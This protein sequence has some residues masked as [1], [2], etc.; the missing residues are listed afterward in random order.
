MDDQQ[1]HHQAVAEDGADGQVAEATVELFTQAQLEKQRLEQDQAGVRGQFLIL[2][3]Q[4]G[5][6]VVFAMDVSFATLHA[7]GLLWFC[8]T[9][10][11]HQFYQTRGRFFMREVHEF[12]YFL[13]SLDFTIGGLHRP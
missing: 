2:E 13:L 5:K 12:W 3:A 9:V 10:W 1:H 6:P 8:W 11:C 4:I 7:N